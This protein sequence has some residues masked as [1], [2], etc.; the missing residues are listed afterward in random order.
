MVTFLQQCLTGISLGG[1]YALIAIGYTLVYGILRLINFA[2]GDL[3]MMSGYFMIFAM[4]AMPW[5]LAIPVVLILTVALGT[6]I[7]KVAY[8]PL[9]NAPRMSVMISAI[10]VSYLLQNLA[11]YLFTA[12][13]KG[14]PAIPFLKKI[15]RFGG[16][17]ASLV[18][19][20]TPILTLVIVYILI[21]LIHH[22]K[23]GMAMRAVAKDYETAQLMGIKI[24]QTISFTFAIGSLLAGIGSILYFTDRMTVFPYSG[25]LP[26]LKCFVAA[27]I[28]GIGSIPGAVVGGFILGLGETA[29]VAMGYSTF[30]D[31]F[32]FVLL[33]VML[34]VRPT[35]IFGEKTVD[36]V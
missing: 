32:T 8:K 31:A 18:T 6:G 1:A 10:G 3:F 13:P 34:L 7:E 5:D 28:G 35:G 36:K 29:L 33:I 11:T 16:L 9:R 19:F 22:S 24:N 26:G 15:I 25:S 21:L 14:Y 20:L 27:V 17:S 23:M 2:H 4:A 12:L 30:S